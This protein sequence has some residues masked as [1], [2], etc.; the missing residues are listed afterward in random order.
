MILLR[1]IAHL[2][3][4]L[5]LLPLAS[6]SAQTDPNEI[7][8]VDLPIGR[9][10]P[11]TTPTA[12]TR[13][14]VANPEV[15]D[16]V[17]VGQRDLVINGKGGGETDLIV[18][19]TDAPRRHYRVQVRSAG[20]RRMVLLSVKIAE[21]RRDV[22]HELGVNGYFR[23]QSSSNDTRAGTGLFRTD[24]AFNP[25]GSIDVPSDTRFLTILSDLGT[26][27][28]LAFIDAQEQRG[29][30]RLLAE[31][32]LLAADRDSASFL[33]GG[34]LPI[35]VVQPGTGGQSTVT[36]QYREFGVRLAFVPEIVNDSII[37]LHV[38]P[39]VSSLDYANALLIEGFRIPALRTRRVNST[40]DVKRDQSLVISGLMN[41]ER[42]RVRTGIPLL[43]NIPI[44]GALFSSTR[45]Q[46]NESELLIVV[47]PA[48]MDANRPRGD[49]VLPLQPDSASGLPANG[50]IEKRLTV[51][52]SPPARQ[53]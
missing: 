49:R 19:I 50:A 18:W 41:E 31:P 3:L 1:R 39:E 14:S 44:L 28:F 27:E 46:T 25:D 21:V 9:S 30:A 11:V 5:A 8:H 24:N 42:E 22:L 7:I 33:A 16:V 32:N 12:I 52:A 51:P 2:G 45:W 35:P 34:E 20:D 36:I 26:S 23:S 47:T 53:P 10:Y 15:A 48:I 40:V 29:N 17:V 37:K 43:S 6:A 4:V 38:R 13:I